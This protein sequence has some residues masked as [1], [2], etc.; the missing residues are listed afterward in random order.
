[1]IF[2]K[3]RVIW[4]VVVFLILFAFMPT[5][6][7]VVDH[8]AKHKFCHKFGICTVDFYHSYGR[9]LAHYADGTIES[10]CPDRNYGPPVIIL[11]SFA[12]LVVVYGIIMLLDSLYIKYRDI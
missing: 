2:N 1:M 12:W 5:M 4:T 9:V 10:F 3:R 7:C 6:R 8:E 11:L